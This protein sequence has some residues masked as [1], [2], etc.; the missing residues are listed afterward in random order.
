MYITCIHV[1][2]NAFNIPGVVPRFKIR[3][4]GRAECNERARKRAAT[5]YSQTIGSFFKKPRNEPTPTEG[6]N[7]PL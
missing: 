2:T 1:S 5:K 7:I 6:K 4:P 3:M